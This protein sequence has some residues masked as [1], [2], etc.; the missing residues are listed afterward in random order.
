MICA[1]FV[2]WYKYYYGKAL[3]TRTT[4]EQKRLDKAFKR[5]YPVN[6]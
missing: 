6:N 5:I 2:C 3:K 4:I 1:F